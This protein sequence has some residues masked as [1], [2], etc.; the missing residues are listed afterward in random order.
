MRLDAT[1]LGALASVGVC[2][3][4][5]ADVGAV[6]ELGRSTTAPVL[7]GDLTEGDPPVVL[8]GDSCS[9]VLVHPRVVLYASHCGTGIHEAVVRA[10]RLVPDYCEAFPSDGVVPKDLAY[11]VLDS[12]AA[13]SATVTPATGCEDSWVQPGTSLAIKGR[14][15]PSLEEIEATVTVHTRGDAILALGAGVGVCGGDS[16]GPAMV[17]LHTASSARVRRLVGVVSHGS[18]GCSEGEIWITPVAPL[19]PWLEARTGLD[20]TPCGEADG[21]WAPGP[22]CRARAGADPGA[23]N[24]AL[25]DFCGQPAS[26][27][28]PSDPIPPVV[29]LGVA[30]RRESQGSFDLVPAVDATDD[31][32]G[33]REVTLAVEG[34]TEIPASVRS[35]RPYRFRDL[36]LE[37][38]HYRL[39]ATAMDYADNSTTTSIALELEFTPRELS[40]QFVRAPIRAGT[41][42]WALVL[43]VLGIVIA[44]G[45]GGVGVPRLRRHQRHQKTAGLS[46]GDVASRSKDRTASRRERAPDRGQLRSVRRSPCER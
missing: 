26:L 34:D 29:T 46:L 13:S 8:V 42:A 37:P 10:E 36:R 30:E 2:C 17:D 18:A 23:A 11:C 24:T 41:R 1:Q 6:D 22:D 21:T 44:R 3:L 25:W 39:V 4:S 16:G 35:L 33:V 20:L 27:P 28:T 40:C 7:G 14:G 45:V 9:G 43:G 31:G 5:C 12:S 19:V 38:G 32:W 15:L